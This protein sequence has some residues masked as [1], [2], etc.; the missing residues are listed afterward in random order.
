MSRMITEIDL[1]HSPGEMVVA[2]EEEMVEEDF[3]IE[4]LEVIRGK[5]VLE[6]IEVAIKV[7]EME[8][9]QVIR[10][11]MVEEEMGGVEEEMVGETT[12]ETSNMAETLEIRSR[13]R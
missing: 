4:M 9:I 2:S 8:E 7:N 6:V 12:L 5:E 1:E 11:T 10:E 13:N 3:R